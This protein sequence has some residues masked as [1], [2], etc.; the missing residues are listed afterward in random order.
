[1][2]QVS[3]AR[4]FERWRTLT[5]A[6]FLVGVAL[7]LAGPG[8]RVGGL[9]L[10]AITFPL[11][12]FCCNRC[13]RCGESFSRAVEYQDSDTDGLPLFGRIARCPF[14]AEPLAPHAR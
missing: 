9:V 6:C 4:R 8:V 10:I 14:C 13:P 3:F 2:E 11:Y 7:C 5:R 1:M 12:F